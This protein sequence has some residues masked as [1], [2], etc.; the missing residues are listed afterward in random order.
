MAS[1]ATPADLVARYDVRVIGHLCNDENKTIHPTQ[2]E[3]NAN[4]LTA[5]ADAS[6]EIDAALL[7]GRRYSKADLD[8]LTGESLSYLKRICCQVAYWFLFERRSW[9]EDERYEVAKERGRK[10]IERLRRGEHVF[11]VEE[12]K[13]AG[14]PQITGPTRVQFRDQNLL[15]DVASP[16][17]PQRRLQRGRG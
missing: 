11:D 6:G 10:A 8:A 12:T 7:Q 13:D 17:Y 1:Y 16:F 5:L 15:R 4:V 14:L 2:I 9:V 3:A